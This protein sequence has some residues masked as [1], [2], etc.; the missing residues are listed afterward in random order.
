MKRTILSVTLL[1]ILAI[2]I[3]G[4]A[5]LTNTT[6][7]EIQRT[8]DVTGT[9]KVTI[10][11]DIA[12]INIGV[13]SQSPEVMGAFTQNNEIAE[14]ITQKLMA[15]G[16]DQKDIQTRNFNIYQQ[17]ETA[18]DPEGEQPTMTYVVENTVTVIV[19][20]L[21]ALGEVLSS[22]VSEGANSIN[23]ITFDLADRDAA[24]KEARQLAIEDAKSQAKQIADTAGIKLGKI[25]R[26]S[27]NQNESVTPQAQFAQEQAAA[28]AEVP[29]SSGTMNVQVTVRLSYGFD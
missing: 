22:V 5:G 16:I 7:S 21:D 20:N 19:R 15:M 3:S 4:C 1:L 8:I 11:P 23:G 27:I 29:T 18:R 26:I 28:P 25:L 6:G 2:S 10:K 14:K 13:R 12:R 17:Q 24:I 9:G